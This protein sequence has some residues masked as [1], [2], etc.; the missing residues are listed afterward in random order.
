[1]Q[2]TRINEETIVYCVTKIAEYGVDY[3]L[4]LNQCL[5]IAKA[6]LGKQAQ[7]RGR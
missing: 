5:Y 1:M 7:I 3:D 4:C 6:Y 2:K